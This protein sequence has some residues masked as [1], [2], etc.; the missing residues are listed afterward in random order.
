M[1]R[2]ERTSRF[3]HGVASDPLT[4]RMVIWTRLSG[5]LGIHPV[6]VRWRV[7]E[8]DGGRPIA[9][10]QS[11]A[12]PDADWTVRADVRGLRPDTAYLYDF[13]VAGELSPQG[14]ARTLRVGDP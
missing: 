12:R 14:R 8:A 3:E 4:T 5:A 9:N 10:G 7:L 2:F 11:L 6:A 1:D 13:E